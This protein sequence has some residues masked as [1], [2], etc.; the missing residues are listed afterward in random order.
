MYQPG[1][2]DGWTQEEHVIFVSGKP[3]VINPPQTPPHIPQVFVFSVLLHF[4]NTEQVRLKE[5]TVP[6]FHVENQI[7]RGFQIKEGNR[8]KEA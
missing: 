4:Q 3:E 5:A 2:C 7:W 8:N 1:G 6:S